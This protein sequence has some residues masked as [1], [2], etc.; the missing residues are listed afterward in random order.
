[1]MKMDWKET[2]LRFIRVGGAGIIAWTLLM[3]SGL[4]QTPEIVLATA[5]I[6][7]LDKYC[8]DQGIY[9]TT[10]TKALTAAKTA[11]KG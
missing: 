6:V 5:I 2:I 7:A 1:M 4:A 8:R 9:G 10:Q 3:L 11:I